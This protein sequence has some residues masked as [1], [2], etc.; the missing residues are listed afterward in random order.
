MRLDLAAA[1]RWGL[2]RRTARDAVRDGRIEVDGVVS[3]E[4]GREISETSRLEYDPDRPVRRR[5]RTRLSVLAEDE[6][7]VIVDKPAGLLTVPTAE[8]ERDTLL[9]RVL[10][11][12]HHRYRRRP[13]A[14]VVHRID[15]D[16]SGAVVFARNRE[17]LHAL[18]DLFR[19]HAIEREYVAL[20]EGDLAG[21]GRFDADL[22]RDGGDRRRSI[23]RRGEPGK[24]AV[25]RYRVLESLSAAAL[26]SVE[27]ETGRTHQIRVHFS[28]GGHP[29]LGDP[30]YRPRGMG[31]PPV[32][33]PRQMLHARRLGFV[34]PRTEARVLAESPLPA[35][36]SE[37]VARL[38]AKRKAPRD[39]RGA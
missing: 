4:P 11:Y 39:S 15:R 13:L 18:Q 37:V 6:D 33:A 23:A 38:K 14:F 8:R 24:R 9:A 32:E 16:T 3:D 30:V 26:V 1:R 29:V 2:S 35:D 27:L 22:V 36:F 34:H 21:S 10:D 12:L 20:V 7:F 28:A 5:V 31:P 17:T 19:R 25:T